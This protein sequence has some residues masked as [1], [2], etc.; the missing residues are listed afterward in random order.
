M[1]LN[2]DW[3]PQISG[4]SLRFPGLAL[5]TKPEEH[6]DMVSFGEEYVLGLDGDQL[7][8]CYPADSQDLIKEWRILAKN[9]IEKDSKYQ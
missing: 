9:V 3:T 5:C 6:I 2:P 8:Q 7:G 1:G 4:A